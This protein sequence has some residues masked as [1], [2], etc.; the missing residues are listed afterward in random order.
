V[1]YFHWVFTL[2]APLRPLALQNPAPIYTLLFAAASA[3]L[4]QF[5]RERL[6]AVLGITAIVHTWG[7]NLMN[8]PHLHCLVTGGGLTQANTWVGPKQ[9]RWLFP[10][11]AVGAMFRGKFCAGLLKLHATGQLQFHGKLEFLRQ[12]QAF[13][14]FLRSLRE[15]KWNVFAKGSVVGAD[16]VLNYLGRYTHRVALADGRLRALDA[17]RQ[18]VSFTY[19]DYADG[20]RR[21]E[22]TLTGEEFVRR[23]CLHL[24]P[25]GFTKIRHYGLLG[26]NARKKLIPRAQ[27]ALENSPWRFAPKSPPAPAPTTPEIQPGQ[28]CPFCQSRDLRALARINGRGGIVWSRLPLAQKTQPTDTS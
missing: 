13:T 27:A 1:R 12:P 3:T 2:P 5:G 15:K 7:Q 11:H 19:K 8:H 28:V 24:L 20:D 21:K 25:A 22:M 17:A 10:I 4:L 26:N 6:G 23:F 18:T 14:Q 9:R 16:A